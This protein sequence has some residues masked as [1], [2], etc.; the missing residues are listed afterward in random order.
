M[1]EIRT[2]AEKHAESLEEER[3]SRGDDGRIHDRRVTHK[4][5]LQKR[6][7]TKRFTPLTEKRAR[8]LKEICH[9]RVLRFPPFSEGRVLGNNRTDWC[10][11]HHITGHSTEACWTLKTQIERLVQ[12]GRLNQYI[13]LQDERRGQGSDGQKKERLDRRERSRSRQGSPVPRRGTIT[14]IS[15]G[16]SGPRPL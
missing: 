5:D 15:G 7:D 14:T 13:R 9:T 12:E 4:P 16:I 11:F 10:D 1:E 3:S 8:I 6:P 2:R